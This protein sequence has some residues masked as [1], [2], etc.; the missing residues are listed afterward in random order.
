MSHKGSDNERTWFRFNNIHTLYIWR[1]WKTNSFIQYLYFGLCEN[2][3]TLQNVVYMYLFCW[4]KCPIAPEVI[5]CV[6]ESVW[7]RLWMRCGKEGAH[8]HTKKITIFTSLY[9]IKTWPNNIQSGKVRCFQKPLV[10][11]YYTLLSS[12][13]SRK[14]HN[15]TYENNFFDEFTKKYLSTFPSY[16]SILFFSDTRVITS[17]SDTQAQCMC[18]GKGLDLTMICNCLSQI[19]ILAVAPSSF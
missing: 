18:R 11:V 9:I 17:I 8:T 1:E 7:K 16:S 14:T 4:S 2:R 13:S 6:F 5:I 19:I 12:S 15:H 10:Y 3:R